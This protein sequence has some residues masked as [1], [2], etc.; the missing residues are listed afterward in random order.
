MTNHAA[1]CVVLL[2]QCPNRNMFIQMLMDNFCFLLRCPDS[3]CLSLFQDY[4][5]RIYFSIK[6]R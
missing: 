3:F 4:H 6:K 5:L 2:F 1:I